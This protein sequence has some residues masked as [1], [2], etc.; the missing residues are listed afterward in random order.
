MPRTAL[1]EGGGG[2]APNRG[3]GF[4]ESTVGWGEGTLG[5]PPR[6]CAT[7]GRVG[8]GE[9]GDGGGEAQLRP[10]E[11]GLLSPPSLHLTPHI[12][13]RLVGPPLH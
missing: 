5:L 11:K 7:T 10:Y 13:R 6:A 2:D 12:M 4:S 3:Q 8:A 1:L 9:A